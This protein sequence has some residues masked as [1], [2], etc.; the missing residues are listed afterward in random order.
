[1]MRSL[2]LVLAL[3]PAVAVAA[4]AC[5]DPPPAAQCHDLPA[6]GCPLDHGADACTD[7]SCAAVYAC[8]SGSWVL[9]H[10]CPGYSPD[11]APQPAEAAT[12]SGAAPSDATLDAPPGAYG[13]P[14]CGDLQAPDCSLGTALSCSGTT[15]CCGC[16]DLYVCSGGGWSLWGQCVDGGISSPP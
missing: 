12:D 14:G 13:G 7:P 11:A 1:M 2:G 3:A 15:D 5:N 16:A 8:E 4:A 6:A 10:A 9:V